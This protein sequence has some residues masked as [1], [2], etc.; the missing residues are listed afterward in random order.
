MSDHDADLRRDMDQAKLLGL[1]R[2]MWMIR[3]FELGLE[4]AFEQGNVPGMLH[5]GLGQEATQAWRLT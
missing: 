2:D 1:Y 3:S 5:T 4:R